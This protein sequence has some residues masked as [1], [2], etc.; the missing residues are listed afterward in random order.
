MNKQKHSY[1]IQFIPRHI[2]LSSLFTF[3]IYLSAQPSYPNNLDLEGGQSIFIGL[4]PE[5]LSVAYDSIFLFADKQSSAKF[6]YQNI[7]ASACEDT[8]CKPIIIT[9]M[10]DLLGNY[11]GFRL[12]DGIPLTKIDHE[13]FSESEYH[14]LHTILADDDS[15]LGSFS[16][17]NISKLL[18]TKSGSQ[19]QYDVDAVSGAT[20]PEIK[21]KIVE[22]ALYTCHTLW[23]LCR[24]KV[25]H[26][27]V[28]HTETNLINEEF[29]HQLIVSQKL[30]FV[31][32]AFRILDSICTSN[33]HM[34]ILE[35]IK[36]SHPLLASQA[37]RH[38]PQSLIDN[39]EFVYQLWNLFPHLEYLPQKQI[40]S[41]LSTCHQL[42]ESLLEKLIRYS[43][44]TIES[45]YVQILRIV[46]NQVEI[47]QKEKELL[48]EVSKNRKEELSD[49]TIQLVPT[50]PY[51]ENN[52]H[53][54][55]EILQSLK[56]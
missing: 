44:T 27:L 24:G 31:T 56:N 4:S 18:R 36:D 55:N 25:S 8:V 33:Y 39:H 19:R 17:Q 37:I 49:A 20:P 34:T 47:S 10:W 15:I 21:E 32:F 28:S 5:E 43:G 9:L 1:A 12:I 26:Q 54:R 53:L 13:P 46:L 22:G 14:K 7:Y 3:S 16:K 50:L 6:Y 2:L 42:S 41:K 11:Q 52:L 29:L 38:L 30:H 35:A 23:H 51:H 40:L 48:H 45:Q